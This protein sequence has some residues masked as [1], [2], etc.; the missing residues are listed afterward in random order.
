MSSSSDDVSVPYSCAICSRPCTK[1][2]Y[3]G[4]RACLGCRAFFRRARAANRFEKFVCAAGDGGC[5]VSG[6]NGGGGG[7][8]KRKVCPYCRHKKCLEAGMNPAWMLSD[9][10]REERRRRRR[11][12]KTSDSQP[13]SSSCHQVVSALPPAPPSM[14]FTAEEL[15][16]LQRIVSTTNDI[17]LDAFVSNMLVYRITSR[18]IFNMSVYG[19]RPGTA[20]IEGLEKF[21]WGTIQTLCERYGILNLQGEWFPS[22]ISCLWWQVPRLQPDQSF[23]SPVAAGKEL[24]RP[25]HP[26]GGKLLSPGGI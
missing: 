1:Y 3:Y 14:V 2:L 16:Q 17:Y 13:T 6:E 24:S 10:D 19:T 20:F 15:L 18:T 9:E 7:A 12:R 11:G 25:V 23:G 5:D 4:A 21:K 8:E 22:T 26:D